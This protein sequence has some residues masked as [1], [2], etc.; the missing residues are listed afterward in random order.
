MRKGLVS[1]V[2]LL[3]LVLST[4]TFSQT[5][6][7][8]LGG[9]ISDATGALI[10]G[11]TITATNTGTGIV[12]TVLTNEA[13]AYQFASLQ[14]GSYAV[15]AELPGFQTQTRS[16]VALGVSQQVRLNF[17][18]QVGSVA[19]TVEVSVAADTLIATS[20][21]SVGTV[22]PEYKIRDMPLGGRN[23]MDLLGA[24]AGTGPTEDNFD[25]FFA[26]GRLNAVNVTRDGFNVTDGRYNYGALTNTY[27][28]PDLVEEVRV[29]TS[30]V[31]AEMG[32]GSG[33]VQMVTRSGTNQLRGSAFWTN[34]NS[35]LDASK[36][37][38]NF[39]GVPKDYENRNQFGAR[40]GGPIIK[41]KTFFF[42][43]VDEQRYIIRQT[44]VGTVLTPLARQGIFNPSAFSAAIHPGRAS[45]R[46]VLS[47]KP[48]WLECPCRMT[49]QARATQWH[50]PQ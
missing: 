13:G 16:G 19:Q 28:S 6:N 25:G 34:R 23:V 17:T 33:Q 18:L 39:N 12:T 7:A 1:A 44:F 29:V 37:F 41:N 31:D 8:T 40:L 32:R 36:W 3:C 38:N 27:T 10:P 43:L 49:S 21:S 42:V 45:I 30:P 26:G 15:T 48:C 14:T 46:R 4:H 2:A 11:V 35:A 22:L 5:S 9:I 47:R 20:S 24:Q 50:R